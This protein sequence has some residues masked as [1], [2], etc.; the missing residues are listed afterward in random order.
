M[1]TKDIK[2]TTIIKLDL[3]NTISDASCNELA[4]AICDAIYKKLD[5]KNHSIEYYTK[6]TKECEYQLVFTEYGT[7]DYYPSNNWY[8]PDDWDEPTTLC[9]DD[10]D[11]AVS[12][13]KHEDSHTPE[14]DGECIDSLYVMSC[15]WEEC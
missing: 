6:K 12:D 15:E 13:V 2:Q 5:T 7:I 10:Y 3:M 8:E 1:I 9:E 11:D 14:E 4:D